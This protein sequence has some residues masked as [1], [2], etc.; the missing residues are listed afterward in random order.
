MSEQ[1]P[2]HRPNAGLNLIVTFV[3]VLIAVFLLA[4]GTGTHFPYQ[5]A[6]AQSFA[7]E[8]IAAVPPM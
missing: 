1:D 6:A 8:G 4:Y 5:S 3:V 2:D 7:N